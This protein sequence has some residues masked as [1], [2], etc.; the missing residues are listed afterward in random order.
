VTIS[1]Q[2]PTR[3]HKINVRADFLAARRETSSSG[4]VAAQ[5][6]ALVCED[7]AYDQAKRQALALLDSGFH[8]GGVHR[9]DRAQLHDR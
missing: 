7:E 8:L 3:S 2:P 1:K 4:L 6:E 5:I 9:G